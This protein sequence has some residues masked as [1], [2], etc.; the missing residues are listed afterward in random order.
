MKARLRMQAYNTIGIYVHICTSIKV[1][2]MTLSRDVKKAHIRV[3][4]CMYGL[5][6][7][8]GRFYIKFPI[9]Q[10]LDQKLKLYSLFA[11]SAICG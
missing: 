3:T 11:R 9:I 5:G 8:F 7:I 6:M 10:I 2:V 4:A 1:H